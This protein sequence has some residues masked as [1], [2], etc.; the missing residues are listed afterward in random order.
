MI[1]LRKIILQCGVKEELKWGVPCYTLDNKN[2]L[3][4]SALKESVCLS[5]FKGALL[6]DEQKILEKAGENSQSGR[7]IKFTDIESIIRSEKAI[8]SYIAEAIAIEKSGKKIER[9]TYPNP[10]PDELLEA[11][12]SD[13]SFEAAF[14][15]LTPGRQRGY[16]IHFSQ[17]KQAQTRVNRIEKYRTQ[18]L[19]GKG[20]HDNYKC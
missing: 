9:N 19:N 7:L 12:K 4:V 15:R 1:L 16:I 8:Q 11:F 14:Y 6:K 17:P 18:I 10:L 13:P 2:I 5:F 20:M 3:I